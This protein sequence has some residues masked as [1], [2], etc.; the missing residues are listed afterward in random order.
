M[1]VWRR[2]TGQ[3]KEEGLHVI[4]L[5][6]EGAPG[7]WG[8]LIPVY[9]SARTAINDFQTGHWGWGLVNTGMAISD[10]FLVKSLAT[11]GGKLAVA[12][13]VA[14]S[15][16]GAIGATGKVGEAAL[17]ELVGGISQKYFATP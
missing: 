6:A 10:V 16:R 2:T 15:E 11:A 13:I 9:G 3:E 5:A 8:G 4:A 12:G 14:L 17:K 7:F 1:G